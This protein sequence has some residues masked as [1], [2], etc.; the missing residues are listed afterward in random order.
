MREI[1]RYKE[2]LLI[3]IIRIVANIIM[4]GAIFL[5]MYM[6]QTSVGGG[7]MTLCAWFFG[8]TIPTWIVAL[9]LTRYVRRLARGRSV[10][11]VVLPGSDKPCLVEWTVIESPR[12]ATPGEKSS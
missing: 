6:A 5:G 11:M 9:Y 7:M 4:V 2:A 1:S 10:S 12:S 8:V 3:S